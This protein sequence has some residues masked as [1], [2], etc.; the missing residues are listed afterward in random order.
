MSILNELISAL[1]QVVMFAFIPILVWVFK[2][3]KQSF[4]EYIGLVK[5]KGDLK[6]IVY[7]MILALIILS[8]IGILIIKLSN[9]KLLANQNYRFDS[10]E[11]IIITLIYAFVKTGLS[12][13]ILF[14]GFA[15]KRLLQVLSFEK[16]NLLQATIFGLVH[17]LMMIGLSMNIGLIVVVFFFTTLVGYIFG[18]INEKLANGSIVPSIIAHGIANTI[19][20]IFI[21]LL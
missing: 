7:N 21:N 8:V 16:A 12:E 11:T 2:Y 13:E 15:L 3:K 18:Y 4:F 6:K 20:T 5:V 1:V 19:S 14:R 10:F 17:V 9:T